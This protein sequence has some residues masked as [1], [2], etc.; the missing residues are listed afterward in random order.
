MLQQ[1]LRHAADFGSWA[2]KDTD[3]QLVKLHV[4]AG[5]FCHTEGRYV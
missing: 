1:E 4:K 3:G 2:A 5:Y